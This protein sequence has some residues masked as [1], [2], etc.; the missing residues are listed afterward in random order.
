MSTFVLNDY[1]KIGDIKSIKDIIVNN[2]ELGPTEY[3]Y[4]LYGACEGG[5]LEAVKL[6]VEMGAA[7][8][9]DNLFTV[10]SYGYME[11]LKYL[12]STGN[13]YVHK[14]GHGIM[15]AC[16]G[17]HYHILE[18][19]IKLRNPDGV[20][21]YKGLCYVYDKPS[22]NLVMAKLLIESGAYNLHNIYD[23]KSNPSRIMSMLELG[24]SIKYL[25]SIKGYTELITDLSNY[26][27]EIYKTME[28]YTIDSVISIIQSYSIL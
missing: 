3:K 11:I 5:S 13:I 8:I 23:Y 26:K 25:E 2:T 9:T 15:G 1:C 21:L 6:M 18:Y 14:Y 20:A 4:G 16:Y 17:N 28:Q 24:V 27:I 7:D 12:I 19:M 10:C 22:P